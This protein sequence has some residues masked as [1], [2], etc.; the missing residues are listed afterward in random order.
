MLDRR[1]GGNGGLSLRRVSS[2]IKIL[3]YQQRMN[4]TEPE[5]VWLTERL[6]H[7][8]DSMVANGTESMDFS[9]ESIWVE[10][11]MGYHTGAG[12]QILAS[13]VWGLPEKRRAIYEY[14]PEIK[15]IL[16]MDVERFMTG[17]CEIE[18]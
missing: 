3:Q 15:M 11:P 4:N 17:L 14:C 5:D 1:Y 18:W 2:I 12:G 6:G 9:A 10:H 13:G 16:D 8:P 7:L